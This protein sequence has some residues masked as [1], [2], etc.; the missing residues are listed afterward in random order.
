MKKLF[1][2]LI[3]AVLLNSCDNDGIGVD[4]GM[5]DSTVLVKFKET[6]DPAYDISHTAASMFL[7]FDS[8]TRAMEYYDMPYSDDPE[9]MWHV[10]TMMINHSDDIIIDKIHTAEEIIKSYVKQCF[11]GAAIPEVT[12]D[13]V[14]NPESL[15][16]ITS[17]LTDY[18]YSAY[19]VEFGDILDN[20][21]GTYTAYINFM[22]N[23]DGSIGN[24]YIFTLRKGNP[25]SVVLV[26]T[27]EL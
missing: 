27:L 6:D 1:V 21:D 13:V 17:V 2:I 8:I 3:F 9:F 15:T 23:A 19:T 7:V 11:Y 12:G 14:Y 16:Y 22:V 4:I 5:D 10:L 24:Q 26:S 25:Y 18:N 20:Y